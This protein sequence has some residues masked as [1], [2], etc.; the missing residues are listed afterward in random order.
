MIESH[1]CLQ[2]TDGLLMIWCPGCEAYH[3]VWTNKPNELT[4]AKW[5]FNGS[6]ENPTF[7]PSILVRG[8]VPPTD[9]E[10]RRILAGEAIEPV[11]TVCH[12]F[13]REGHIEF[14]GDCT[15]PLK[16]QTVPLLTNA[17]IETAR[18]AGTLFREKVKC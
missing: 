12:S 7:S 10:V 9:D 8:T 16:G 6:F 2:S 4:G 11:P 3:G 18:D 17:E 13:V 14:L 15:H 1:R 5:S